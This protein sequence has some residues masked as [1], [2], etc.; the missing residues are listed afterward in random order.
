MAKAG[1]TRNAAYLVRPDGHVGLVKET[2][3]AQAFA[4][5]VAR[6]G[7]KPRNRSRMTRSPIDC[8][9]PGGLTDA[10]SRGCVKNKQMI[11]RQGDANGITLL[12]G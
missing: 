3:D 8:E 2:Q 11:L 12:A 6:L 7:I 5:Y 1:L 10:L 4:A 9:S